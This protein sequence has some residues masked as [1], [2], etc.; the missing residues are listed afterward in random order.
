PTPRQPLYSRP[1]LINSVQSPPPRRDYALRNLHLRPAPRRAAMPRA[2]ARGLA[3]GSDPARASLGAHGSA[4]GGR[5]RG[6]AAVGGCTPR[7]P[8]QRAVRGG[9]ARLVLEHVLDRA[10]DA[11]AAHRFALPLPRVIG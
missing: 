7:L 9:A 10:R 11:R 2:R 3:W 8:R 6:G 4:C 5:A 1:R